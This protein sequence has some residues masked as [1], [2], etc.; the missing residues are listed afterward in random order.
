MARTC[1]LSEL[2]DEDL[3]ALAQAESGH[4]AFTVLLERYQH[5]IC[6]FVARMAG[7]IGSE[8]LAQDVFIRACQALPRFRGDSSFRTWLYRIAHNRCCSEL[9]RRG[10]R[11]ET[12]PLDAADAEPARHA[13][14]ASTPADFA[15]DIVRQ[16]FSARVAAHVAALPLP[17]RQLLTLFYVDEMQYEEIAAVLDVPLGTVKTWLHRARLRLRD[18]IVADENLCDDLAVA[19]PRRR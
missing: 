14:L 15:D 1:S 7:P 9:R 13:L 12:V 16:D 8:D 4:E 3:V 11:I 17:Y 18:A 10:R 2:A 6:R 19:V 5:G